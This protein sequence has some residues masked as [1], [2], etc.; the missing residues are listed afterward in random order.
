MTSK[1]PK[2]TV[3]GGSTDFGLGSDL[4]ILL[5]NL[6]LAMTSNFRYAIQ[7]SFGPMN[8][9]VVTLKGILWNVS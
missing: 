1:L 2:P 5:V 9:T 4:G 3:Q 7:L 8:E 6:D